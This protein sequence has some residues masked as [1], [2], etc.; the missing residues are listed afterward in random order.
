[1]NTSD[2]PPTPGPVRSLWDAVRVPGATPPL[3]TAH[4]RVYY[5]ASPRDDDTERRTNILPADPAGAPYPVVI[6]LS[7]VN[8]AQDA[9]RWLA[10]RLAQDG[11]VAVTA[12]FVGVLP[13]GSHGTGPGLDPASIVPGGYGHGPTTPLPGALL[14]ALRKIAA[15][16]SATPL[17]GRLD[18]DRIALA[19]H[20]AGG[21]LALQSARFLPGIRAVVAYGAHLRPAAI[22]GWPPDTLLPAHTDAP[23]LLIAGE[24]DDVIAASADRY[25]G[26]LPDPVAATFAHSLTDAAGEH[27]YAVVRGAGHFA[28]TDSDDDTTARGFLETPRTDV[29]PAAIRAPL[30]ALIGTFCLAHLR[31]DARARARLHA[32]ADP[33]WHAHV[34]VAGRR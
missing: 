20:S 19:G 24:H 32:P 33:A 30:A 2:A 5:P 17:A 25:A 8:V 16:D 12:D 6:L 21:T 23:V 14:H 3:D 4:L 27:M 22:L 18:L 1:M 26:S 9:Y 29:D 13:G 15:A 31:D 34:R 28:I 11:L 10:T 7:G